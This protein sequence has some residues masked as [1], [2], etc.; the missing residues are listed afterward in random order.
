MPPLPNEPPP[1][2]PKRGQK[3]QSSSSSI[4]SID[5]IVDIA[6]EDQDNVITTSM[7]TFSLTVQSDVEEH[8]LRDSGISMTDHTNL[9]NF[10]NTCYEDFDLRAHQQEMNINV[11][12]QESSPKTENPPPI[13]PKCSFGSLSSSL[14]GGGTLERKTGSVDGIE[15]PEN[16]SVPK[17][18]A[19][20]PLEI[21]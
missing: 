12:P 3:K 5:S 19:D 10:N 9:N 7:N 16:Y 18:F 2:I 14:D 8:D 4:F 21:P 17:L 11:S 15:C 6:L 13:P 20:R 1:N